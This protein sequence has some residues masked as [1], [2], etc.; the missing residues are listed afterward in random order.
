MAG[1]TGVF[2]DPWAAR[3]WVEVLAAVR[4]R[5]IKCFIWIPIVAHDAAG[6]ITHGFAFCHDLV[7]HFR[8]NFAYGL[9]LL[10]TCHTSG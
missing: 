8:T 3:V 2:I 6:W 1:S 4:D 7:E 5:S 9:Y 10:M